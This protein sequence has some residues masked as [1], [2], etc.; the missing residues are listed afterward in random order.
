TEKLVRFK[1]DRTGEQE[2]KYSKEKF[3]RAFKGKQLKKK[4][5]TQEEI[6]NEFE[7]ILQRLLLTCRRAE[8]GIV[9]R[10]TY[11]MLYEQTLGVL[12]EVEKFVSE[13]KIRPP[14][15]ISKRK[16][17]L[18]KAYESGKL[19]PIKD[20]YGNLKQDINKFL[21]RKQLQEIINK[22]TD[23]EKE[24]TNTEKQEFTKAGIPIKAGDKIISKS[25]NFNKG[26]LVTFKGK[27]CR[28]FAIIKTSEGDRIIIEPLD[29]QGK[30]LRINVKDTRLKPLEET[31]AKAK[32]EIQPKKQVQKGVEE[33]KQGIKAALQKKLQKTPEKVEK[34]K[35]RVKPKKEA[36]A[37]EVV[38]D[39]VSLK[40]GDV[41]S[42]FSSSLS[43]TEY[44]EIVKIDKEIVTYRL[45]SEGSKEFTKPKAE[46][47]ASLEGKFV[48]K[49][50]HPP[51]N[52]L[53]AME[54]NR[55]KFEEFDSVLKET[56]L[57]SEGQILS[58]KH[59]KP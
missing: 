50:E 55:E 48:K 31:E 7:D 36:E 15:S 49:E 58:R 16:A 34:E 25:G 38:V 57:T 1:L 53:A 39:G 59:T 5:K 52:Y 42:Y 40:A 6:E 18:K 46:F 19:K 41:F 47:K 51:I 30:Y 8:A 28:I 4:P 23:L 29:S 3:Q 12:D 37:K 17:E 21:E 56:L 22:K 14:F 43:K 11:K 10:A 33:L 27:E 13:N 20:F 26:D 35:Q 44:V 54:K 32:P 24:I 9:M 2:Y 45:F